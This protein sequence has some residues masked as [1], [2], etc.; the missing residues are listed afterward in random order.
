ML[1]EKSDGTIKDVI[2]LKTY[3]VRV[4]AQIPSIADQ[5]TVQRR[6]RRDLYIY[7]TAACYGLAVLALFAYE[8]LY[9]L[10]G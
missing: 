8:S 9:R 5:Q 10:K 1:L 3:G 6:K 4:L 7:L 2:D